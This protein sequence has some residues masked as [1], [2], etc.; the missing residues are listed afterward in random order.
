MSLCCTIT[1]QEFT[2]E[3]TTTVPYTG[4]EP[5]VNVYYVQPDGSYREDFMVQKVLGASSVVISHGGPAT[6]FVKLTQ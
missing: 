4:D 3:V 5:T 1:T 2:N 6:G